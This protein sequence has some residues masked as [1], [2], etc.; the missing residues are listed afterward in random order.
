MEKRKI[1][2]ISSI[3]PYK[4]ANL[5][6]DIISSLQEE[7]YEVDF[8]TQYKIPSKN[9]ISIEENTEPQ[10]ES[11]PSISKSKRT[12]F[13]KRLKNKIKSYFYGK[14]KLKDENNQFVIISLDEVHPPINT[15]LIT[16]K[17]TK[18]YDFAI[19]L[20]WQGMLTTYSIEKIY[21]KI[22][23]PLFIMAVDMFPFTGGCFYFWNCRRFINS[24]CG[25]C[26]G[27]NSQV[28]ND[29]TRQN[30]LYKQQVYKNIQCLFLGNKWM[31]SYIEQT[32]IISGKPVRELPLV[33]NENIFKVRD[34]KSVAKDFN[35]EIEDDLFII[36]A[37]APSL[38]EKRKG[39]LYLVQAIKLFTQILPRHKRSKVRLLVAGNAF[40]DIENY[41]NIKVYKLGFL[42]YEM[43]AKAY[44]LANVYLSSSIEDAGPS[45]V[46]QAIMSG[47]P[48]VAFNIGVAQEIV[49]TGKTGYQAKVRDAKDF[50]KG[51]HFIYSLSREERNI[52]QQNC[53][54]LGITEFSY[55]AFAHR[56]KQYDKEFCYN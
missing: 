44:S 22:K 26:P 45:M 49:I 31:K 42:N 1:L 2:I 48:V 4:S 12:S 8:L 19:I 27:L 14:R 30:Y 10:V 20:F 37:G 18:A 47:T 39:F 28:E 6:M 11:L 17:I 36:F 50:A 40:D 3:S 5:G 46:N 9:V 32:S 52:I 38:N 34:R 24:S 13:F 16:S 29:A 56:I 35:I 54:E 15:D 33:I 21:N 23:K 43:L 41:F 25:K 7:G 53:R 55:K 51:I